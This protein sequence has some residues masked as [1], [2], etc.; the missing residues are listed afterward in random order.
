ML[1]V[2]ESV[3]ASKHAASNE[4]GASLLDA[5]ADLASWARTADAWTLLAADRDFAASEPSIGTALDALDEA[6]LNEWIFHGGKVTGSRIDVRFLGLRALDEGVDATLANY[7]HLGR[8]EV[9]RALETVKPFARAT[10]AGTEA[11]TDAEAG[12]AS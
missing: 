7:P 9:E 4:P 2:I 12:G 3:L 8:D 5:A 1:L 11:G 10:E 6:F